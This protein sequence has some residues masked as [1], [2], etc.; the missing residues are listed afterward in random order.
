MDALAALSL[1]GIIFYNKFELKV[2]LKNGEEWFNKIIK[3]FNKSLE[4]AKNE[5]KEY[6]KIL[7]NCCKNNKLTGEN[8]IDD[9]DEIVINLGKEGLYFF[10]L[11]RNKR[12]ILDVNDIAVVQQQR[13]ESLTPVEDDISLINIS[14]IYK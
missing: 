6:L 5:E 4:K 3:N 1:D 14:S 7:K 10:I 9:D 11:K 8:E 12:L 2:E 13:S